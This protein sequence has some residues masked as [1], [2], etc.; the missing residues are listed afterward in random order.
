MT[1]QRITDSLT[2]L[3]TTHPVV[4]WHD[5]EAEFASI[6]DSLQL[7]GVQL[8]RL[9]DTPAL[10]IKLDIDRDPT[11]RWLIYSAKPEPEPTKD[12][13]LDVR[14]RSKSFQADSTSIL[15]EDLGLTT[16]SLRQHLKDRA[17]FLRA[18]D[19]VDRLKRLVLSTDT[20]ADLDAKM[21]AVLTRADQPELFAML[22]KLY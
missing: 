1:Q 19:R 18:K 21:L 8:V 12:W 13:L 10:R 17:K 3:F 14:L 16:Q 15:L 9:D 4:F 11:K 22:Q 7:D 6:V 5:V 2:T 20:A